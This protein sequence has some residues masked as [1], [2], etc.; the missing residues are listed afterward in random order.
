MQTRNKTV[1]LFN[2]LPDIIGSIIISY[3]VSTV[4]EWNRLQRVCKW[5]YRCCK[6]KIAYENIRIYF[7]GISNFYENINRYLPHIKYLTLKNAYCN[8]MA[9]QMLSKHTN[10]KEVSLLNILFV[11]AFSYKIVFQTWKTLTGLHLQNCN[12]DDNALYSIPTT[13]LQ[14][15]I[16]KCDQVILFSLSHLIHLTTLNIYFNE[17]TYALS[18]ISKL[19]SLHKLSLSYCIIDT[20]SMI[21]LSHSNISEL[22]L[23][24]PGI[25]NL[26]IAKLYIAS[27]TRLSHI[28]FCD[29][30]YLTNDGIS[31]L[32]KSISSLTL[33]LKSITFMNCEGLDDNISIYL[34]KANPYLNIYAN[35][36]DKN[37]LMLSSDKQE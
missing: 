24:G 29:C 22:M 17:V 6:H 37:I 25:L 35:D 30:C 11:P 33:P 18:T 27:N 34:L 23:S 15:T 1:K 19:P 16:G 32:S 21:N 31:C 13:L 14:L 12:I 8:E 20:D 28:S 4:I 5:L 7:I 3:C 10:V 36:T 2:E 9:F 26:H